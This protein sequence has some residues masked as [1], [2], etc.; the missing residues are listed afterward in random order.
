MLHAVVMRFDSLREIEASALTFVNRMPH[1]RMGSYQIG[2]LWGMPAQKGASRLLETTISCR[3]M[4]T[5]T[6]ATFVF[7]K[8]G[9]THRARI[10]SYV[11]TKTS[12]R[13]CK[14]QEVQLLTNSFD[15]DQDPVF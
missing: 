9:M 5:W 14:E 2:A 1:L 12:G 7:H 8:D 10:V 11:E 4:R 15:L 13:G 3:S 6:M